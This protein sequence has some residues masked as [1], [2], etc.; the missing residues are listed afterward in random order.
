[1]SDDTP[2]T[3]PPEVAGG[4]DAGPQEA[5]SPMTTLL[6]SDAVSLMLAARAVDKG[7]GTPEAVIA[8][9]RDLDR[10]LRDRLPWPSGLLCGGVAPD[11][12]ER[13]GG[14]RT[15]RSN[16]RRPSPV[17]AMARYGGVGTPG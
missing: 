7:G 1:M 6:R 9:R 2:G 16:S 4:G 12:Y 11:F 17:S 5:E 14:R 3:P 8:A 13:P 10:E 15:A